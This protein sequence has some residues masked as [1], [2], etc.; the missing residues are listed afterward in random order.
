M[1]VLGLCRPSYTLSPALSN[2]TGNGCY[3][4]RWKSFPGFLKLAGP[5]WW[6][7]NV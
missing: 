6:L 3:F 4:L 5:I 7:S 1:A 2:N